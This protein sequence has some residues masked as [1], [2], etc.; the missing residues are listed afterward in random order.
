[1]KLALC[2][3]LAL[4]VCAFARLNQPKDIH[5]RY[6]IGAVDDFLNGVA[7]AL[8]ITDRSDLRQCSHDEEKLQNA[9]QK[10]IDLIREQGLKPLPTILRYLGGIEYLM[11]EALENCK[12]DGVSV[13]KVV[14]DIANLFA[15]QPRRPIQDYIYNALFHSED[16]VKLAQAAQKAVD[17]KDFLLLGKT[18]GL[19]SAE[20]AI[21]NKAVP[22]IIV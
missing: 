13:E 8:N 9:T 21:I 18:L 10:L 1:M 20:I 6:I 14:L 19:I 16:L 11:A 5:P 3:V 12:E 7:D 4:F 17:D 22:D 2:L 15:S